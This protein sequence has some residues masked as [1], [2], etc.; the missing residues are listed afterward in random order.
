MMW[1]GGQMPWSSA[2]DCLCMRSG[3]H[4]R[5]WRSSRALISVFLR[6]NQVLKHL[7]WTKF[8]N[9][10]GKRHHCTISH[11]T[12]N[13]TNTHCNY[14]LWKEGMKY[15]SQHS[16]CNKVILAWEAIVCILKIILTSQAHSFPNHLQF[17]FRNVL[18]FIP[19]I[20]CI[21]EKLIWD[22]QGWSCIDGIHW[23]GLITSV[24][25]DK[26]VFI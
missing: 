17:V 25:T 12:D 23:H 14:K 3:D 20:L 26:L 6:L 2:I 10:E 19:G 7:E 9:K 5:T 8:R 11:M 18:N 21:D 24:I 4:P 22:S 15:Q 13:P 1:M 16:E